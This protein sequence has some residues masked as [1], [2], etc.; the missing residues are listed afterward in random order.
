MLTFLK[1]DLDSTDVSGKQLKRIT[2]KTGSSGCVI[3]FKI[4]Q[5]RMIYKPNNDYSGNN[6]GATVILK[7]PFHDIKESKVLDLT[8]YFFRKGQQSFLTFN[9]DNTNKQSNR[10]SY[11]TSK[12]NEELD[13]LPNNDNVNLEV[14]E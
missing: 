9:N 2:Y 14:L 4:M 3:D 12:I 10:I 13:I 6:D 5:I 7:L 8:C 11:D 1:S